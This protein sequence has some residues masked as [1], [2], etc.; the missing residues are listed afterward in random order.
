MSSGF[1]YI[2]FLKLEMCANI[3]E[4][5]ADFNEKIVDVLIPRLCNA[6]I[7]DWSGIIGYTFDSVI[8]F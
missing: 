3:S 6:F 2:C 8:I 5:V 1:M 4:D 7:M